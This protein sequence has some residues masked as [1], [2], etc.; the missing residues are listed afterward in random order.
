MSATATGARPRRR[1]VASAALV[2]ALLA[3]FAVTDPLPRAARADQG[4]ATPAVTDAAAVTDAPAAA[5]AS[6]TA[7]TSAR[8][9]RTRKPPYDVVALG[10]S[11]P[12]GTRCDCTAFPDLVASALGERTGRRARSANRAVPGLDTEELREQLRHRAVRRDL[13]RADLVL[14]TIGANDLRYRPHCGAAL[15]CYRAQLDDMES[16][17]RHVLHRVYRLIPGSGSIVVTGYWSV[18]EDGAVARSRGATFVSAARTVT[19]EANRILHRQVRRLG[20]RYVDLTDAIRPDGVDATPL[21]AA[22]GDHPNANGHRA[23]A[24]LLVRSL[25]V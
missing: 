10:D 1:L 23:I 19:A 22:D 25:R 5:G 15:G 3:V 17:L 16:T 18:W 8:T 20:E 6:S 4:R 7:V 14:V 9:D 11:V 21:L 2:A 12:A 13:R 24:A